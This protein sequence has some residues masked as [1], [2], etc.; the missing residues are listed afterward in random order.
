MGRW[1]IVSLLMFTVH[2]AHYVDGWNSA[3][4]VEVGCFLPW[5]A[6]NHEGY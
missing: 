1:D 3:K 4:Q 5:K 6:Q 2:E